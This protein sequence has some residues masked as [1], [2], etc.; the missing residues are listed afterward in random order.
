VRTGGCCRGV[1]IHDSM[2]ARPDSLP[3]RFDVLD[4]VIVPFDFLVVLVS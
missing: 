3:T 4:R 2:L 1:L